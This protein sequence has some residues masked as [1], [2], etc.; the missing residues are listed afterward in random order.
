VI[1]F[2]LPSRSGLEPRI[3]AIFILDFEGAV[4]V[5][6]CI[7][8]LRKE[9]NSINSLVIIIIECIFRIEVFYKI[10]GRSHGDI[11]S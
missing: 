10:R 11:Y 4:G 9:M 2:C 7:L 1:D 5:L 3:G 6:N 8:F